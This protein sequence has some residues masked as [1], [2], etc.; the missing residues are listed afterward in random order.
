M[1]ALIGFTGSGKS[2]LGR[3][4]SVRFGLTC[5]DVDALIEQRMGQ[6][7]HALFRDYGESYFRQLEHDQIE[8][9]V[10]SGQQGVLVTGGGAVLRE[11]TRKLLLKMCF[12]VQIWAPFEKIR[13]RLRQD[14]TRPLL[15]SKDPDAT[16][17]EL[18][19]AREH[20]YDFAHVCLD[21]Q[22]LHDTTNLL[23]GKWLTL[24]RG[25]WLCAG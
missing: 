13:D 2:T 24:E 15:A 16:L 1:I 22:N 14:Q 6:T 19:Q 17:A 11:D 18:Y 3:E 5:F 10:A 12:V 9:V 25:V 20:L 4:L 7:I 23:M 8:R 21:T